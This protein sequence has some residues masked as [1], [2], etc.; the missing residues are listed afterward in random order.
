MSEEKKMKRNLL[1]NMLF[2]FIVFTVLFLIFDFII[3][4]QIS[5]SLYKDIDK[6]LYM[7]KSKYDGEEQVSQTT[8][9]QETNKS[10][11][12]KDY[13]SMKYIILS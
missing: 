13:Y 10:P 9:K 11:G 6:E 5:I 12:K 8:N 1:K 2:S 7:Q 4:N 3:Y